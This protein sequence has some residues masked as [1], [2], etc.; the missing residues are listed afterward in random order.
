MKFGLTIIILLINITVIYSRNNRYKRFIRFKRR[1]NFYKNNPNIN[2]A[3]IPQ[4]Y[5]INGPY[6]N[7]NDFKYVDNFND[8][9]IKKHNELMNNKIPMIH[10]NFKNADIN[11]TSLNTKNKTKTYKY[12]TKP[13]MVDNKNTTSSTI[14]YHKNKYTKISN[15]IDKDLLNKLNTIISTKIGDI[16]HQKFSEYLKNSIQ[17]NNPNIIL[18]NN[19][20]TN[21]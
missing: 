2:N 21:K 17:N 7:E 10:N 19:L 18:I 6:N 8:D 16:I 3:Y 14:S 9:M 15:K 4:N 12:Y 11:Y 1:L 13:N 20:Y 5:N